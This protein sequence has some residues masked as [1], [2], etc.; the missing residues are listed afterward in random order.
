MRLQGLSAHPMLISI[1]VRP[2]PFWVSHKGHDKGP[3]QVASVACPMLL[4]RVLCHVLRVRSPFVF[5]R[6]MTNVDTPSRFT[7]GEHRGIVEE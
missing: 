1:I 4:P 2:P 7:S 6:V 5:T 3:A